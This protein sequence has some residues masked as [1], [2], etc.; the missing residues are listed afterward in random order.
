MSEPTVSEVLAEVRA[1]RAEVAELNAKFDKAA[2]QINAV[3]EM[4]GPAIEQIASSPLLK[5]MGGK[6][7][8]KAG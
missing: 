2:G 6:R 3:A 4:A 1:M 5:L 7:D 8:R